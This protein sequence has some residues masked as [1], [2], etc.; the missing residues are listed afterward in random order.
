[1]IRSR[2]LGLVI[3][4]PHYA[5]GDEAQGEDGRARAQQHHLYQ[6]QRL[7]TGG[8]LPLE[9]VCRFVIQRSRLVT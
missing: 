7:D 8:E 6:L 1:M 2:Q 3:S 9:H 4:S 5:V